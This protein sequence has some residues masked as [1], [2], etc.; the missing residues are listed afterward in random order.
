MAPG[1]CAL[2]I[3]SQVLVG[4]A[5]SLLFGRRRRPAGGSTPEPVH[6][7]KKKQLKVSRLLLTLSLS[8]GGIG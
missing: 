6:H 4:R 7:L 1:S 5:S 2:R 8:R 3:L